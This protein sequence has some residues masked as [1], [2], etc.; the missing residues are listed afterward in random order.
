MQACVSTVRAYFEIELLFETFKKNLKWLQYQA[1]QCNWL[2]IQYTEEEESAT[3]NSLLASYSSRNTLNFPKYIYAVILSFWF[4]QQQNLKNVHRMRIFFV[5]TFPEKLWQESDQYTNEYK[6]TDG[7]KTKL[8]FTKSLMG[9][10]VNHL[11][12]EWI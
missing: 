12:S 11:S 3:S 5:P 8:V 2:R 10:Q 6:V 4:E 1:P 7:K 9:L